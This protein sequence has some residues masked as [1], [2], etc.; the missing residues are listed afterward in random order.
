MDIRL[1]NQVP[2]GFC[3]EVVNMTKTK[4]TIFLIVNFLV[5]QKSS[6]T[7][8]SPQINFC[9]YA[10]GTVWKFHDFSI[11]QILREISLG[12]SRRAISAISTH[13]EA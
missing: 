8:S 10:K 9:K 3:Y 6:I 2:Q 11:T 1:V 12:D 5:L 7:H 4:H 13:S